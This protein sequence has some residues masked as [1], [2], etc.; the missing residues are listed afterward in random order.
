MFVSVSLCQVPV[1]VFLCVRTLLVSQVDQDITTKDCN[2]YNIEV[3]VLV[4][5]KS[6]DS[7]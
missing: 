2:L 1:D 4:R 6:K 3:L 5:E 7:A